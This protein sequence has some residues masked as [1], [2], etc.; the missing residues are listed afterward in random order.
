MNESA[1]RF[2]PISFA[3]YEFVPRQGA[4]NRDCA[5]KAIVVRRNLPSTPR[6]FALGYGVGG[7]AIQHANLIAGPIV[8]LDSQAPNIER[9]RATVAMRVPSG[10]GI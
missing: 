9:L 6:M 5:A 7:Q 8:N 1:P 4:G 2:W 10:F 3:P